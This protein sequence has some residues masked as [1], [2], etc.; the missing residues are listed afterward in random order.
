MKAI[1]RKVSRLR[2]TPRTLAAVAVSLLLAVPAFAQGTS[3]RTQSTSF[4]RLSPAPSHA[5]CH[6]CTR[7]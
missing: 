6:S 7:R 3:G 1:W 5:P 4:R 2:H